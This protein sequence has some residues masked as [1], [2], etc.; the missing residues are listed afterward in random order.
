M[1]SVGEKVLGTAK[2]TVD[3][4]LWMGPPSVI[5][6]NA[7]L[8]LEV[9]KI[10]E[11][12]LF[13][14][15]ICAHDPLLERFFKECSLDTQLSKS[16]GHDRSPLPSSCPTTCLM[17]PFQPHHQASCHPRNMPSMQLPQGLCSSWSLCWDCCYQNIYM[18]PTLPSF[19][20]LFKCPLI[21]EAFP[22]PP[23]EN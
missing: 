6:G 7:K 22:G 14:P 11:F 10:E 2:I 15:L 12:F 20:T 23:R 13:F 3:S 1:I 19:R 16:P 9:S 17:D 18:A 8:W 4:M 5:K 21:R